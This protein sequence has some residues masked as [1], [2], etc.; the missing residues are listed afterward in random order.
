M[1]IAKEGKCWATCCKITQP[2]NK[3]VV[4]IFFIVVFW[5]V[6]VR[7]RV[8][9]LSTSTR[10]PPSDHKTKKTRPKASDSESSQLIVEGFVVFAAVIPL[11]CHPAGE[12][13]RQHEGLAQN[14]SLVS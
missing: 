10:F 6:Y 9:G 4:D 13:K 7:G 12:W 8:Q 1:F 5:R 2:Y 3:T 11:T 14:F